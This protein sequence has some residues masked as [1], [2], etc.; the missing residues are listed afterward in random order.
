VGLIASLEAM[1]EG[2]RD[3]S[4][5]RFSLGNALLSEQ[6]AEEAVVHLLMAVKHDAG[7]SAAWKL[8]GKAQLAAGNKG[9]AA[10]AYRA[11][12][13]AAEKKGDLQAMKEMQVF[14]RRVEKEIG[15]HAG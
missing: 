4:L 7:F 1:L 13:A 12:I 6:R 11:G 15:K 8:L 5:L 2:G 10:D 3:D 9:A 14:L